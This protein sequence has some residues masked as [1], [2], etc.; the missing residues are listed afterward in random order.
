MG[1]KE[2]PGV[3]DFAAV[4]QRVKQQIER[5]EQHIFEVDFEVLERCVRGFHRSVQILEDQALQSL[6]QDQSM[7]FFLP[8][9]ISDGEFQMENVSE[10]A[11]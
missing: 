8:K 9:K 6:N 2:V 1:V 3:H 4:T 7:E 11:A 5:S 10:L